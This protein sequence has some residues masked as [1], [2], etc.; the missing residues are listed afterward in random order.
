MFTKLSMP[1]CNFTVTA[2]TVSPM[3]DMVFHKTRVLWFLQLCLNLY[4]SII[5]SRFSVYVVKMLAHSASSR[6][7]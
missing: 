3:T 2:T 1:A 6:R 7:E 5:S 4:K